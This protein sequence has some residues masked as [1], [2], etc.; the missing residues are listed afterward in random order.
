M[1][2]ELV[3]AYLKAFLSTP[4]GQATLAF[5]R[6]TGATLVGCWMNAGTPLTPSADQAAAW[7]QLAV[8]AGAALVVANYF[9]PWEKRYGRT[10]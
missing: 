9:G 10:K 3:M 4:A 6:V 1:N 2:K 5:L 8:Q 7:L